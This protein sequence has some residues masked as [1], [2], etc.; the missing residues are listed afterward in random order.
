MS[1]DLAASQVAKSERRA[2]F[3]SRQ[4]KRVF[5]ALL[6]QMTSRSRAQIIRRAGSGDL[7]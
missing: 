5:V 6:M 4:E 2:E 7:R 3:D 1:F